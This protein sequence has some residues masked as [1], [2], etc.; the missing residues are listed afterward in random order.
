VLE[1]GAGG[2]IEDHYHL[3]TEVALRGFWMNY[4]SAMG[5]ENNGH[6]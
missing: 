6:W 5:F 4:H 1:M 2:E 3:C